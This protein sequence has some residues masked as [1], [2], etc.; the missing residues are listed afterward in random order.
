VGGINNGRGGERGG[1]GRWGVD[2][3]EEWTRVG[4]GEERSGR[5]SGGGMEEEKEAERTGKR[6][7][8]WGIAGRKGGKRMSGGVSGIGGRR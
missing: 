3:N 5:G 7:R 2:K 6:G 4:V 1:T 8:K